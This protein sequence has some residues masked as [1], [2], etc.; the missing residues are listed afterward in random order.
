[1]TDRLRI[2]EWNVEIISKF[3]L[4]RT[5]NARELARVVVRQSSLRY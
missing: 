1:M 5:P 3:Y 4:V 2:Y